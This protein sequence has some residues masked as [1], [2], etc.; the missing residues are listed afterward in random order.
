MNRVDHE[1]WAAL[2][3]HVEASGVLAYDVKHEELC[4][5]KDQDHVKLVQPATMSPVIQAAGA[6]TSVS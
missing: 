2:G 3:F 6:Y 4:A 5:A 1:K